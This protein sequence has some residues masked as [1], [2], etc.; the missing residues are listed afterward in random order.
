MWW[1]CRVGL[2]LGGGCYQ[3]HTAASRSTNPI[4][5]RST[6]TYC[7]THALFRMSHSHTPVMPSP[8][9]TCAAP[10]ALQAFQ[11]SHR[12]QSSYLA[13]LA[14]QGHLDHQA[15]LGQCWLC[16]RSRVGCRWPQMQ[17]AGRMLHTA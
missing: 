14:H 9:Q 8:C 13:H 1:I 5:A 10:Q 17:R 15:H 2:R 3:G 6:H 7:N 12:S 4:R 16:L 11:L